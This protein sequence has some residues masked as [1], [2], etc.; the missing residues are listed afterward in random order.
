MPNWCECELRVTGPRT[1]V[2][3]L[4]AVA[5]CGHR[6]FDF[7]RFVPYPE[8]FQQMDDIRENWEKVALSDPVIAQVAGPKSGF[9]S[10][11]KEWCEEHWGTK[12]NARG[13][14][15]GP[16]S[17]F[18]LGSESAAWFEFDTAWSPPRPV[19]KKASELFPELTF[20]LRYF[21]QGMQFNGMFLCKGGEVLVD[22]L[23]RYF[24]RRGG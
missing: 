3:D 21:E 6:P 17:V 18:H 22:E 19:I 24:G 11:G 8:E 16:L 5:K 20:D 9:S 4:I 13:G 12:W 15:G 14:P 1:K 7:N 10:G 2:E 23:G